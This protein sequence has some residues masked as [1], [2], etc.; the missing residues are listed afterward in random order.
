M[1]GCGRRTTG[2]GSQ[3]Y[4]TSLRSVGNATVSS[5]RADSPYVSTPTYGITLYRR[6]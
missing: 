1:R 2:F 5:V 6:V 3:A 4:A